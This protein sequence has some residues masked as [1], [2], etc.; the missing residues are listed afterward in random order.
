[1]T[2]VFQRSTSRCVHT[3]LYCATSA[4]VCMLKQVH[5]DSCAAQGDATGCRQHLVAAL[6]RAVCDGAHALHFRCQEGYCLLVS[7]CRAAAGLSGDGTEVAAAAAY[8]LALAAAADALVAAGACLTLL[9]KPHDF[10]ARPEEY[11]A[12]KQMLHS[13]QP[14]V[15]G[16][17]ELCLERRP[18]YS[19]VR[20]TS[21]GMG[22]KI[23][24]VSGDG[25]LP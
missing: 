15:T 19:V 3:K 1:M 25:G 22:V 10:G 8:A 9:T 12:G 20:N 11:S 24:L 23:S 18:G 21:G 17:S 16:C 4:C 2:I 6:H 14:G 13:R 5:N 7:A